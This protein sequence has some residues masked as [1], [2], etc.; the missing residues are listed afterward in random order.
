MTCT[1]R[2]S[3]LHLIPVVAVILGGLNLVAA[4][5]QAEADLILGAATLEVADLI[6]V[7]A[8]T[9]EAEDA[10]R[11]VVVTA[12]EVAVELVTED[13]ESAQTLLHFEHAFF[14]SSNLVNEFKDQIIVENF[15]LKL[16]VFEAL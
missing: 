4:S 15:K 3:T 11:E 8:A 7:E 5:I 16:I 1:R 9:L 6:L 13:N 10:I 2:L 12:V 14:I